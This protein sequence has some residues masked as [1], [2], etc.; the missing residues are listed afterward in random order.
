MNRR[1][2]AFSLI[3]LLVVIG[4]IAVLL[5]L[6]F[7]ALANAQRAARTVAC[8]SNMRQLGQQLYMYAHENKGFVIPMIDDPTADGGLRGLGSKLPPK[9][10]WPAVVFK[11]KGPEP[12]TNIPADYCPKVIIC[13][14]DLDAL[15][16]HTYALSNPPAIHGCKLGSSDFGG[17]SSSEVVLA[18]EKVTFKNDYYIE[19]NLQDFSEALAWYRHGMRRGANYLFFDGHV[20]LRMPKDVVRGLDPWQTHDDAP[21]Q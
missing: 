12:E 15:S 20:E 5:A 1:A 6:L 9:E 8:Q 14:A 4:I 19:P 18:A 17:L 11:V 3:E 7:P 2:R 21:A 13:P 10:R 16:G